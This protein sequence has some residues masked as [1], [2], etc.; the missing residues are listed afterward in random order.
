MT[1]SP[2]S[3]HGP[4]HNS[5]EQELEISP[6]RAPGQLYFRAES[7]N[8]TW[9]SAGENTGRKVLCKYEGS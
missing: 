1:L 9:P 3:L 4:L 7:V 6:V 8:L 5:A 2:P